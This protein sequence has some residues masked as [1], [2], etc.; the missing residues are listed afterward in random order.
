MIA[1]YKFLKNKKVS[2]TKEFEF[3][4]FNNESNPKQVIQP[5]IKENSCAV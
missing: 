2:K 3:Q 4:E 1:A 5:K